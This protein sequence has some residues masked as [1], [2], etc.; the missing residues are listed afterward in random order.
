MSRVQLELEENG[1]SMAEFTEHLKKL[2]E[3]AGEVMKACQEAEVCILN[4]F[5]LQEEK[6]K[7]S[8]EKIQH[9]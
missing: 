6:R 3:E 7:R 9:E 2:E 1:K 4:T 8:D 5:L